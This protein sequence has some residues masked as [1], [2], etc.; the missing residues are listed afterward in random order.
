[1][2]LSEAIL[3]YPN[4]VTYILPSEASYLNKGTFY[5]SSPSI[6]ANPTSLNFDYT[7]SSQT[8]AIT[9]FPASL[10]TIIS[11]DA[12]WISVDDNDHVDSYTLTIYCA[13]NLTGVTRNGTVRVYEEGDYD[14][15]YVL[16]NITQTAQPI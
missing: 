9:V 3:A 1:M 6:A 10:R 14:N 5:A 7:A 15:T 13:I 4:A 2:T 12:S 8:T 11:D 16:V